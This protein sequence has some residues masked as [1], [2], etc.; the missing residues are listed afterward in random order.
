MWVDCEEA[1]NRR[2]QHM[3]AKESSNSKSKN[4][5]K[6]NK[7]NRN[8]LSHFGAKSNHIE[9]NKCLFC[10]SNEHCIS[11]CTYFSALPLNEKSKFVKS[12]LL[13]YN[14]LRKG[15]RSPKCRLRRCNICS[16]GHHSL[17]HYAQDGEVTNNSVDVSQKSSLHVLNVADHVM[18]ATAIVQIRS[19]SGDFVLARA[20]LDAGS[21]MN[22]CRS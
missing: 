3:V 8:V 4:D 11:N 16:K 9:N 6:Q 12:K 14:C 17:L 18:L 20:L 22:W 2:Y 10:S 7:G 13:C 1:L 21:Q 5:F 15:H 19:K